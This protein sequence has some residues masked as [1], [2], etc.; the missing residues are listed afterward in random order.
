[1]Q[2]KKEFVQ[3]VADA[4]GAEGNKPSSPYNYDRILDEYKLRHDGDK[5]RLHSVMIC[6][7]F[8][9]DEDPSLSIDYERKSWYCFGCE[10]HG[11]T[12]QFLTE[13]ERV[14]G[15]PNCTRASKANAILR[16]D[17]SVRAMVGVDSVYARAA[18]LQQFEPVPLK[19]KKYDVGSTPIT[20]NSLAE[21]IGQSDY[22]KI[23]RSVL[24][25]QKGFTPEL[26][27]ESIFPKKQEEVASK[28]YSIEELWS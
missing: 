9:A 18:S 19:R 12:L 6:C 8:H 24:M 11:D 13:L 25:M 21:K 2:V 7:P 28:K 26:I 15:D 20:F 17:P 1:M 3:R 23:E 14:M 16:E 10:K 5:E 22:E 4:I 27:E